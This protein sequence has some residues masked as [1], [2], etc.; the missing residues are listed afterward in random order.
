MMSLKK[1]GTGEESRGPRTELRTWPPLGCR[2]RRKKARKK[3][4]AGSFEGVRRK[5]EYLK[6]EWPVLPSAAGR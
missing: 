4:R 6:R 1:G 2:R 5:P 3:D